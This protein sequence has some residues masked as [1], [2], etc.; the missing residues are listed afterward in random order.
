VIKLGTKEHK[1]LLNLLKKTRVE[2]GLRQV[3]LA[4]KLRVPQ[5]MISKYEVGE[6]RI[7]LL[8]VRDICSALGISLVEFVQQLETLLNEEPYETDS[9]ISK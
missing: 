1:I 2:A 3:D 8:E 9:K 5:S 7:D 4:K 6:R